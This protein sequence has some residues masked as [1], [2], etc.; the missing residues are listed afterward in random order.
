V[1]VGGWVGVGVG[2][3]ARVLVPMSKFVR[4]KAAWRSWWWCSASPWP[5]HY[6]LSGVCVCVC[7]RVLVSMSKFVREKVAWRS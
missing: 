5:M 1:C 2:V 7:A 4:E 6:N 3:R